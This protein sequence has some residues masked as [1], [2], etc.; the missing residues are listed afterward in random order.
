[1][2]SRPT[3]SG[4]GFLE[5]DGEGETTGGT[6][7]IIRR[8]GTLRRTEVAT[9]GY[10]KQATQVKG[11]LGVASRYVLYTKASGLIYYIRF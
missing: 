5:R 9:R 4:R 1:M 6:P 2:S 8:S 11:T 3:E 10:E 7:G